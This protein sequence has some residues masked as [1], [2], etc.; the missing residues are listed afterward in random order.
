MPVLLSFRDLS[1]HLQAWC[2]IKLTKRR[3]LRWRSDGLPTVVLGPRT[4]RF[5]PQ[6]VESWIMQHTQ[7]LQSEPEP[8]QPSEV[9]G[10]RPSIPPI[11]EQA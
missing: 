9:H 2:G 10:D 1:R 5:D 11:E 6:A 4:I 8:S 3:I 7:A